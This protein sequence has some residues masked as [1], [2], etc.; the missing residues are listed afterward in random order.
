MKLSFIILLLWLV[1]TQPCPAQST[2][3]VPDPMADSL[4]RRWNDL[5][6]SDSTRFAALSDLCWDIYMY[7]QPD[8]V[9]RLAGAGY[10]FGQVVGSP[11][12]SSDAESLLGMA[13]MNKGDFRR[14]LEY[15][16]SS[17][18][19]RV[20]IGEEGAIANAYNKVGIA[21]LRLGNFTEALDFFQRSLDI[22]EHLGKLQAMSY[23]LNNMGVIHH[24]QKDYALGLEYY[25]RSLQLE[26]ELGNPMGVA[27]GLA[28]V[29]GVYAEMDRPQE[30]LDHYRQSLVL[31]EQAGKST[32]IASAYI[33][34]GSVY[35]DTG[36]PDSARIYLARGAALAA[37]TGDAYGASYARIELGSNYLRAGDAARALP[38]CRAGL[39]L[40]EETGVL[41]TMM[42]GYECLYDGY[43]AVGDEERALA[44]FEM[45]ITVRDSIVNETNTREL[46]QREMQYAFD[47]EQAA[48]AAEQ[49]ARLRYQRNRFWWLVALAGV[50][51]LLSISL[52]VTLRYRSAKNKVIQR[53]ANDKEV[54]LRELHHRVKNNLQVISS[55]LSL[56]SHKT[57]DPLAKK[58]ITDSRTRVEAMSLIH[59]KLY[60][61]ENLTS[62]D[63]RGYIEELS[64]VIFEAYGYDRDSAELILDVA[65]IQV[66]VET[67]IPLGLI[68][69]ELLSNT[70]KHGFTDDG[71]HPR[72]RVAL[73]EVDHA[74]HLGMSD[75]GVGLPADFVIPT[76]NPR[77]AK[78]FGTQLLGSLAQQ[79][80]ATLKVGW[81]PGSRFDFII[82]NYKLAV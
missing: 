74:L 80:D 10:R 41:N 81:G 24:E 28:N 15:F 62:I 37:Q 32:G 31:L 27:D 17:L 50:L 26:R 68:I 78:T 72:V 12:I 18:H 11:V 33:N 56:Q 55:I 46:T 49:A 48:A 1:C 19:T 14:A 30:A 16:E 3:T 58:A 5:S 13:Y 76:E 42:M 23:T 38:E 60:Q 21:H 8:S 61:R 36:A 34:M 35:N 71:T 77:E 29:A 59:Q 44:A 79:L 73:A 67:A 82:R 70:F 40:A 4:Y 22:D 45:L 66:D 39:V 51:V 57:E 53:Q 20:A 25:A 52:F 6:L 47:K 2:A 63:I 75:N 54:L 65:P 9:V 69:N 64:G 43:K 7:T